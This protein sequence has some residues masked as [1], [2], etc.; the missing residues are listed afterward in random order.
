V[1]YTFDHA[2]HLGQFG[3][4]KDHGLFYAMGYCGSGVA[5]SSYFGTKLRLKMLGESENETSFDELIFETAPLYTGNSWFM[6]M[7]L[8]WYRLLDRFGM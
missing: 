5:R 3:G 2:L 7:V 4:G 6:P 1:G 8:R